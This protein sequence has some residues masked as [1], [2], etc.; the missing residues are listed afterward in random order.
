[1]RRAL[2]ALLVGT[3]ALPLTAHATVWYLTCRAA[4]SKPPAGF[5][6]RMGTYDR[7]TDCEATRVGTVNVCKLEQQRGRHVQID[8]EHCI[9]ASESWIMP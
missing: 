5:V 1:M 4:P 6:F 8:C 3:L 9:C 2:V 7:S